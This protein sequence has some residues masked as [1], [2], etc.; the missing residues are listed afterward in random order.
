MKADS[1]N[2]SNLNHAAEDGRFYCPVKGCG[3]HYGLKKSL[4]THMRKLHPSH[5]NTDKAVE[6]I[7]E[8]K[9]S[10]IIEEG[11]ENRYEFTQKYQIP[12]RAFEEESKQESNLSTLEGVNHQSEQVL[13]VRKK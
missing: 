6:Q 10:C 8:E 11:D 1:K 4:N 12:D 3:S 9:F 5:E 2:E 7:S 13:E